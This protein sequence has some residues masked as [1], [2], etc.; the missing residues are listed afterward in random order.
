MSD[1]SS[2]GKVNKRSGFALLV[3]AV[4]VFVGV[5]MD[6]TVVCRDSGGFGESLL[7]RAIHA[8]TGTFVTRSRIFFFFFFFF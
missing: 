2:V 7:I 8:T 5:V 4:V 1:N 6:V 3:L